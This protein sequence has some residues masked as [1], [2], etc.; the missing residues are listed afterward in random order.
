MDRFWWWVQQGGNSN[1]ILVA[2]TAWY[3]WLTF[4][5]LR[6]NTAHVREQLRPNLVLTVTRSPKDVTEGHFHIENVG[7][8]DAKI[9]VVSHA[10]G[11]LVP[12]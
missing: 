10:F 4:R 6:W 9:T 11:R 7:E 2:I 8:R 1:I 3:S 5:I 12:L